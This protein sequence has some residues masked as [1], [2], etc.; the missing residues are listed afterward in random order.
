MRRV[1]IIKTS[2][3]GDVVHALP[4]ITDIRRARPELAIDWLVEETFAEIP[5]LHPGVAGVIPC[6]L[7]RWR[8]TFFAGNTRRE[9]LALR[10]A[11]RTTHYEAV[12]D[13]QGLIKSAWLARMVPGVRHGYTFASAREPLASFAYTV[14]HRVK[15]HVELNAVERNRRL[16]AAAFGY[17]LAG[18]VDY[19]L[20]LPCAAIAAPRTLLC[21]HSTSRD[22]K[23]WPETS[24][25]AVLTHY[26]ALGVRVVLPWGSAEERARSLRLQ[27]DVA[28]VEVPEKQSLATLAHWCA[29]ACGVIGV[30]TGLTHLA[31]AAGTPV[32][33]I[34]TASAPLATG[35][36]AAAAPACNVGAPHT[37]PTVA[38]VLAAAREV[39]G[40]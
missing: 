14:R 40:F 9:V 30:D 27:A 1:L 26:A 6:A 21:F 35:V 22:D 15:R 13:L 19:G 20:A 37:T 7:R 8:K 18:A 2:S 39:I 24:W 25:R 16:A 17:T 31:A 38:E 12:L 11:L 5:A 23:L 33:A 3:L 29:Q 4:A 32:V 34:Y 36:I 28:G 10:R